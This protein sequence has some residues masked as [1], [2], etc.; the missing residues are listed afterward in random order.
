MKIFSDASELEGVEKIED[1]PYVQIMRKSMWIID[2]WPKHRHESRFRGYFCVCVN[3]SCLI[4]GII[5]LKNNTG[6]LS[7]FEMGHTY[8]T[9]FMNSIAFSRGLMI[10]TEKYNNILFYFLNEI[11]LFNS[12]KKSDYSYQTHILVHKISHFFTIYLL[13]L[14]CLGILFFNLT[15]MYNS[16][17]EGMYRDERPPNATY[18]HAVFY[19]LP[20]DYTTDLRGYLAVYAFNWYIS[21][22]CSTHFC[23]VDLIISL[24]VFHLWGHMRILRHNLENFPKPASLLIE[25]KDGTM[26]NHKYNEQEQID[27]HNRLRENLHYHSLIIDFQRRMSD[28]FG[29]ILLLYMLFHQVSECLLMLECSQ[30]DKKALL[31]YGP[32]TVVIFQQLIQLSIIFELLGSSNDKLIDA[33]YCVPWEYME[34]KDSKM[35][36]VML[37]QSQVSMNLKAMSMLTVGVQTMIA[38]LKT[39]FSY[40]VMLQTVAEEE[41]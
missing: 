39:S 27:I 11:H 4:P 15:P 36:L 1:I 22:T 41:E 2:A 19:S 33:V 38:I 9:V 18:D 35:V 6:K 14:M 32:L 8:I 23:V 21:C 13:M 37:M 7:S 40:F 31:R 30:M 20:F 29:A 5:Y 12:R 26:Q 34:A 25:S 10:L 28:S 16:Y 3:I 24:M 17:S